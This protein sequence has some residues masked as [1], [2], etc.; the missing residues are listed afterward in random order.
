[1]EVR[2]FDWDSSRKGASQLPRTKTIRL[3]TQ[4][5]TTGENLIL[6]YTSPLSGLCKNKKIKNKTVHCTGQFSLHEQAVLVSSVSV[7]S[8]SKVHSATLR[9]HGSILTYIL[10]CGFMFG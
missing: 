10:C 6:G 3:S 5:T 8:V 1:M 9:D 7:K 2:E 4:K